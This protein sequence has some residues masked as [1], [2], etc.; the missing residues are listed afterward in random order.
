MLSDPV[1]SYP[2]LFGPNSLFGGD[3]GVQW[4]IKFPYALPMLA[5]FFFMIIC[6]IL[7]AF[8]LE[9]VSISMHML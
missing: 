4:L 1:S 6:A 7:V 9:E 3:S 8:G 5:N 2:N